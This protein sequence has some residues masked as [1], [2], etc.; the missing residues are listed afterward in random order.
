MCS[1]KFRKKNKPI[2]LRDK[3]NQIYTTALYI[4]GYILWFSYA[5]KVWS[6]SLSEIQYI[7]PVIVVGAVIMHKMLDA[8]TKHLSATYGQ[9][10]IFLG[11]CG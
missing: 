11:P 4:P 2:V 3:N 6:K 7:C 8:V 1:Q 10:K 9:L 5:F